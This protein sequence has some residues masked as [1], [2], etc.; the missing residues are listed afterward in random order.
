MKGM[1]LMMIVMTVSLV[2]AF[3][4]DKVPL[5]S[6]TAHFLLDPTFGKL[7]NWNN[8]VGLLIIVLA[9]NFLLTL[10]HKYS[11]NQDALKRIKEESKV[12]REEMK[13][14]QKNQ[15]QE[16]IAELSK[17]SMSFMKEQFEH[18]F[19]SITYTAVPLIL[20][21][22]WFNDFFISIGDPKLFL[23]FKWFGTYLIF[24]IVFSTIFRKL[25]K[26]H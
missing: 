22:R 15:D 19:G 21:F 13:E 17:K 8:L 3:A 5:I 23:I 25:L 16:K 4:W 12:V 11:T 6:G 14:A 20:F 24:S 10:V 26:V 1:R 7:I 18:S 2:I 9:L